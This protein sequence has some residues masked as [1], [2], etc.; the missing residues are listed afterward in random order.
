MDTVLNKLLKRFENIVANGRL[1]QGYFV[2]GDD[3]QQLKNFVYSL[4]EICV[5][6]KF[7]GHDVVAYPYLSEL[8]PRSVS[9]L[10]RVDEIREFEKHFQIKAEKGWLRIGIIWESDRMN[11]QAQ[12][13]FLKTLEEPGPGTL[14][15]LVSVRPGGMLP[16]IRSRC[17]VIPLRTGCSYDIDDREKILAT[18]YSLKPGAGAEKALVASNVIKECFGNLGLMAEE[19]VEL[20]PKMDNETKAEKKQREDTNKALLRS[21]YLSLREQYIG[22]IYSWFS[23]LVLIANGVAIDKLP[24]PE[25]YDQGAPEWLKSVKE[26]DAEYQLRCSQEFCD[27]LKLNVKEDLLIEDFLLKVT[28]KR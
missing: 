8:K 1:G 22:L 24:H 16:T 25:F 20:I 18:L 12:N 11:E 6:D 28:E 4:I 5:R 26:A 23:Q 17:Q 10:I 19:R 9:R 14:I 2:V 3:L 13:A 15:I 27:T 7:T 21:E